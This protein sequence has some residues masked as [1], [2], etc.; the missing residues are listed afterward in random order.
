[1]KYSDLE[2]ISD[3][4]EMISPPGDTLA[5][6]I[7]FKGISQTEL[8]TRMNRPVKTINEIIKGKA[9]ITS[10][11]AIQLEH[12][13]GIEAKFWLE[14]EKNYRLELAEI[15]EAETLL[16]NNEWLNSFP[17]KEMKKLQWLDFEN[18]AVSRGNALLVFFGVA[19][20][21]AYTETY[22]KT[23][24]ASAYRMSTSNQKNPYA[25]SA[26]LR[27][28]EHQADRLTAQPYN[29]AQFKTV[30]EEMKRVM[31]EQPVDFFAK[32]QIQC[33][34]AGVKVVHTPNLPQTNLY[35][36]TRWLNDTPLI[37]LSNMFK[38]NDS[39][40]FTFFH[41]AGHIILHGKRDVFVEGFEYSPEEQI[42]EEEA[43]EF[44]KKIMLNKKDEETIKQNLPLDKNKIEN[45]ATQFNTHPAVIVGRL[46]RENEN[47][48]KLGWHFKYYQKIDLT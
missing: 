31:I 18:N 38:R 25:V 41:E 20:F 34:Q 33:L 22:F 39:F 26:W 45:F 3:A 30:L 8:A 47:L 27:Q 21:T 43:N 15:E 40:W 35:G 23:V 13:L 7:E 16:K 19:N 4:K 36:S 10:E 37:Q 44:A 32:I 46:A 28:G 9:A 14:R 2:E 5:E 17:L 6:T 29:E 11:T 24:Y 1:M 12:V 42:K 48:H